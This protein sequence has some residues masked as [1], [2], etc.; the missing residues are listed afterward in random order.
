MHTRT[1]AHTHAHT[2]TR[3]HTRIHEHTHIRTHTRVYESMEKSYVVYYM[4][5]SIKLVVIIPL[6]A[7]VRMLLIL[8]LLFTWLT[9]EASG[10]FAVAVVVELK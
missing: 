9:L 2:H 10:V 7:C 4:Q 5:I 8:N 3:T 1:H 6:H